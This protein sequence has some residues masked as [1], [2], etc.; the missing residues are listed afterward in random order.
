MK[1][2]YKILGVTKKTSDEE[3]RKSYRKLAMQ[4]H[5]DRNPDNPAAEEQFKAVSEA[6]EILSDPKKRAEYDE[7]RS[8]FERGGFR[9]DAGPT[10]ITAPFLFDELFELFDEKLS[11]HLDFV[12]LDPGRRAVW[13]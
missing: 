6:Y 5:P 12:P 7:A 9:H 11:D 13:C 4:Y 8:L 3:L 10:V 2:Y 1:D